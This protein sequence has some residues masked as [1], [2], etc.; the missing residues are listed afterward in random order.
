MCN[1]LMHV[2][3]ASACTRVYIVVHPHAC[4]FSMRVFMHASVCACVCLWGGG[5]GA[6]IDV[7]NLCIFTV[8]YRGLES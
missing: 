5:A 7:T 2:H 4:V 6:D 8:Q 3:P 1:L